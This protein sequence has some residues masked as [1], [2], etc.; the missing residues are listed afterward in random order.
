LI[1]SLPGGHALYVNNTGTIQGYEARAVSRMIVFAVVGSVE[2]APKEH[3]VDIPAG[4]DPSMIC[5][6]DISHTWRVLCLALSDSTL[7]HVSFV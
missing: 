2:V 3:T 5:D 7:Y 1:W 4:V 6:V